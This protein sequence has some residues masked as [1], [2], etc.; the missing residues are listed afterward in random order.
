MDHRG[1]P[2][3]LP[4]SRS[5]TSNCEAAE[6]FL[7]RLSLAR[8]SWIRDHLGMDGSLSAS[9]E[10]P[11]GDPARPQIGRAVLGSLLVAVVF[12]AF[13]WSAKE[14]RGLYVHEPWQDDPYDAVVS[15]AIFFVPFLAGLCMLRVPLCRREASLPVRRALDLLRASCVL[16]GV[17]LVTL[18]SDWISVVLQAHRSVW[19]ATTAV[20]ICLLALVTALTVAVARELR[21]A[22]R[23]P[24]GRDNPPY[25]PDW[26]ADAVTLA[27]REATRLGPWRRNALSALRW[28]DRRVVAAARRHPLAAAAALSL[29]FGIAAD[30]PKAVEEGYAPR[31]LLLVFAVSACSMFA[32][33]VIVGT[34]L[35][36]AGQGQWP[37]G[38]IVHAF[39]AACVSLP[40]AGAFRGSIWSLLGDSGRHSGWTRLWV[41]LLL[42]AV[43]TAVATFAVESFLSGRRRNHARPEDPTV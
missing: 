38:R 23:Q 30:I 1:D 8:G 43:M 4:E 2:S 39:V 11:V 25:L 22:G 35:N 16:V 41:L 36:L 28:V 17:V 19:T 31:G 13:T 40:L 26:L 37:K 18:L 9:W 3:P 33:L 6:T 32:F 27:E 12:V 21:R 29:A 24:L 34:H 7:S 10:F 14:L 15:F 20:I 5:G 42:A